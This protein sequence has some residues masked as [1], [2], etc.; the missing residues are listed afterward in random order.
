MNLYMLDTNICIE[1]IRGRSQRLLAKLR[2]Q[3]VGTVGISTITLAELWHGVSKS[4]DPARNTVALAHMVAALRVMPF[5][6]RAAAAYGRVRTLLEL[7]GTPIGPL[8]T[9]IA[10]HALSLGAVL[11]TGNTREFHRAP[12]LTI[13]NWTSDD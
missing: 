2:R 10:G 13:E 12:G 3:T 6:D 4:S 9:L 11:V 1:L 7:A 8:D 5:D